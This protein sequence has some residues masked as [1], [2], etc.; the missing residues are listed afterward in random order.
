MSQRH[1]TKDKGDLAVAK[2]ILNLRKHRIYTCLPISEHLPFDLIAVMP[3][4]KT[5][6]RVQVK[7]R[8]DVG[9][10]A[11][12]IK[13][14]SNYYDSKHIYTK[15]VN[16]NEFD[17]YAAYSPDT[18]KVYYINIKEIPETV[19]G[20]KIR[21]VPAKSNRKKDVWTASDYVDP[22]RIA[23]MCDEGLTAKRE[24]SELDELA[25]TYITSDLM[26][27]GIQVIIPQSQ[28]VPF[29]LIGVM[30]DMKTMYRI[31]VGYEQVCV[32]PNVDQYAIFNPDDETVVYVDAREIPENISVLNLNT[33]AG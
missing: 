15:P 21:F 12:D 24:V 31:R 18:R 1:I 28:Y 4:M 25:I 5:L 14:R 20:I 9:T 26:D 32:T 13:L 8:A 11:L 16:R 6:R 22:R 29:D 33:V 2:T 30:E 19:K 7:Y 27:K 3:D 23:P 10:G 17:C